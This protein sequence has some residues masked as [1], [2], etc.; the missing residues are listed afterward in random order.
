[1]RARLLL[2][3]LLLSFA[4]TPSF[5]SFSGKPENPPSPA[6]GTTPEASD[7]KTPR[8]QAESWYNDAYDDVSKAKDALAAEKPDAKK[9]EKLFKR[10]IERADRALEFDKTY[11]EALNLKGFSWRKLGNYPK[12][13]ESYAAC[14]AIQPD[15][16]PAR[17]YYGEAL[18]ESGDREGAEGQLAWLKKLNADELAK[19]LETAL[20][21]TPATDASKTGK[22][23]GDAKGDAKTTTGTTS[24]SSSNDPH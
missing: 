4:V 24:G 8:Q 17:E 5:A 11:F 22:A 9:A 21:A 6:P 7:Q 14:L 15:Y 2:P 3:L 23:K 10:S 12:S 1:M 18:L 13:L 16:A 19:Q 20:A